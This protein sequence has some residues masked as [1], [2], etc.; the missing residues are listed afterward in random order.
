MENIYGKDVMNEKG[1]KKKGKVRITHN[2]IFSFS[3]KNETMKT[4]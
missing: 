3:F 4:T 1:K 2:K